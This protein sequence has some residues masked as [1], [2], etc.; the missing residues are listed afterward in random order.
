MRKKK[1]DDCHRNNG[2]QKYYFTEQESCPNRIFKQDKHFTITEQ[3]L[4]ELYCTS[5]TDQ[6]TGGVFFSNKLRSNVL[7]FKN[8]SFFPAAEYFN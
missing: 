1:K 8:I 4:S 7:V 5:P 3:N 6:S 2:E